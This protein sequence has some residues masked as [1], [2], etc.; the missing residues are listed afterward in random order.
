MEKTKIGLS[1]G[2]LGA[3]I[4][5]AGLYGGYVATLFL[6]GYVLLFETNE[7]LRKSAVRVV[8]LMFTF[9]VILTFVNLLPN[10]I[11]IVNY[12]AAM[13]GGSVYIAFIS[14]FI[15]A[16]VSVINLVEKFVFIGIGVMSL[17]QKNITIPGIDHLI[18]K[19]M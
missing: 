16:V 2:L 14:N 17:G 9:S 19:H 15:N 10:I 1:V 3:I 18:D 6:V 7:W 11:S 8:A 13:F 4:C 12:L 5:F